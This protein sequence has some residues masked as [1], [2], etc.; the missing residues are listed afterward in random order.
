MSITISIPGATAD[1][2]QAGLAA[3]YA[4]FAAAGV[5]AEEAAEAHFDSGWG[6]RGFPGG[7]QAEDIARLASLW[8][9]AD[10]AAVNACCSGWASK[11]ERARLAL[12]E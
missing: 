9:A 2:L 3:A 11:P 10:S 12:V 8:E 4:V 7:P 1:E 5:T 6:V